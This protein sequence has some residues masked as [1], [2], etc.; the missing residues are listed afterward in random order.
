MIFKSHSKKPPLV[1]VVIVL[2]T[3]IHFGQGS[4]WPRLLI[5]HTIYYS[6]VIASQLELSS[7]HS[8][9]ERAFQV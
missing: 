7:E 3:H 2:A 9:S 5:H 1:V 6:K 4:L 8:P